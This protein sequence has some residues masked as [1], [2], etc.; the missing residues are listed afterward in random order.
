MKRQ[1]KSN[2]PAKDSHFSDDVARRAAVQSRLN[3]RNQ[4]STQ[5]H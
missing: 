4:R 3:H 1:R 5:R 2:H